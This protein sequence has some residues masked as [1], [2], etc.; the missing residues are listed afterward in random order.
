[1]TD[2]YTT[3]RAAALLGIRPGSVRALIA[4]KLLTATRHGRDWLITHE[5]IEKY[6]SNRRPAHRPKRE[7]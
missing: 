2:S 4:R 6:Q 3:L 7:Q 1:M 5:S